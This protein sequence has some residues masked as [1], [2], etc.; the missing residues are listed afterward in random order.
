MRLLITPCLLVAAVSTYAAL[1]AFPGAEG[2]GSATIGGRAGKVIHVTNL[3]NS[4]SGSLR[5]ATDETGPR[6]VVFD[7]SGTIEL[8]NPLVIHDPFITIAGQTAPGDG[9]TLKGAT[10]GIDTH[11]VVVRFIRSRMGEADK[12][13]EDAISIFSGYNIVLDHVSA[14]WSVDEGLSPSGN[15]RDI[16]VQWS[17]IAEPL[18]HSRHTKGDHGYGM[19]L[20]ATGGISLHHN[21]YAHADARN[22]RFG[23]NYFRGDAPTFDFRNNVIYGWGR[24]ASGMVDGRMSVNYVNNYLKPGP[25]SSKRAPIVLT[26]KANEDTRFY[27]NGNI[28]VGRD[29]LTQDNGKLFATEDVKS[30]KTGYTH[31]TAEFTVPPVKTVSATEAY[32]QVLSQAGAS[33]PKRDAVDE[34]IVQQVRSG[35]GKL[36]DSPSDVG[37]WPQLK[38]LPT[39]LDTDQDGIPD[40]WEITH[41][42][43]PKNPADGNGSHA[44]GYTWLEMYLNE[45]VE[46]KL[47]GFGK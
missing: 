14:S 8:W 34:R 4:G 3:N 23:D 33:V 11:D 18:V 13:S 21:L 24:I 36:V 1:P 35:T 42:L 31:A 43:D 27:V 6:T 2:F 22:P 20:R 12:K 16:T 29:T 5:A 46:K 7:V 37:G 10:F 26:D 41:N 25:D 30:G 38:S 28:V 39:P 17:T 45:L 19:L 47:P 40:E 44:S 9:I 32:E 15:L